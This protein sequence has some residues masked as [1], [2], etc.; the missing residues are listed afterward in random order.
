[1]DERAFAEEIVKEV[2]RIAEAAWLNA[3]NVDVQV[4]AAKLLVDL[5]QLGAKVLR[6]SLERFDA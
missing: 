1:M 6:K 2:E 4:A 5:A 3:R